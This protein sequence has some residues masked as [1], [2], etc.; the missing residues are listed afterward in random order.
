MDLKGWGRCTGGSNGI[1]IKIS[2][3]RSYT[4]G[5]GRDLDGDNDGMVLN[6]TFVQ[7]SAQ[8]C[9]PTRNTRQF[10][11]GAVAGH[12]FAHALGAAHE[13][14]RP[15]A[16]AGCD[17][18]QGSNGD[19]TVGPWDAESITNGLC[20]PRWLNDGI[21][22]R[23]DVTGF[24]VLYPPPQR[25]VNVFYR[26]ANGHIQQVYRAG[27]WQTGDVTQW[28]NAPL[29]TGSPTSH[30]HKG[31]LHVYYASPGTGN[32]QQLLWTPSQ[33]W[34]HA[35]MSI[36]VPAAGNPASVGIQDY[37]HVFYRG[38]DDHLH[39]L[40]HDGVQF[41]PVDLTATY[42]APLIASDPAVYTM[43]NSVH[44][45]YRA[46][47]N[48]LIHLAWELDTGWQPT[49]LTATRFVDPML[50]TP[51]VT[52]LGFIQSIYY[53][54]TDLRIH[55]MTNDYKNGDVFIHSIPSVTASVLASSEPAVHTRG[56]LIN[57]FFRGA[58]NHIHESYLDPNNSPP[59]Y[60]QTDLTSWTGA[61][62]ASGT[63][64]S[65]AVG[66][67]QYVFYTSANG[68]LQLLTGTST[69]WSNSSLAAVA[70]A[71]NPTGRVATAV[72]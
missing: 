4:N 55:R 20:N 54:G 57:V 69:G 48:H 6:F 28:T 68:S 11:M 40:F 32:I 9:G 51:T 24:G 58:D 37:T 59:V 26:T 42:G 62:S 44:I 71:P 34:R 43:A 46:P 38:S 19:T 67:Q 72:H 14:N 35:Q 8:T 36:N 25:I 31:V 3:E 15:D 63:P 30:D 33:G 29:A 1:R 47:N 39:Q 17:T 21:L 56:R 27:T 12:E 22:S 65:I 23:G 41:T 52:Q 53:L 45:A 64:V 2:D 66:S 18:N 49:D 13:Q 7:D 61:P 50:G 60:V 5:I 16:P 10:C 70:G